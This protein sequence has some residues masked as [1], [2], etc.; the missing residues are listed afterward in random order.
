MGFIKGMVLSFMILIAICSATQGEIT[1]TTD[2]G[3]KVILD[4][5]GTW[6]YRESITVTKKSDTA[7][8]KLDLV[9]GKATVYYQSEKW[10]GLKETQP[11]R[12]ELS[13]RSGDVHCVIIAERLQMTLEAL[14]TLALN[15]GKE[16]A[17]DI[18]VVKED[19][20]VVNG[21]EILFMQLEGTITGVPFTYLGY[22]YAGPAGT[23]QTLTMTG[24]NLLDEYR[25][26]M[27]EFLN[28]FTVIK[29]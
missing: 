5:N 20:R 17:P 8:A 3:K 29:E 21:K 15:N 10:K 22:Y 19:R 24:Q 12:Y 18:K 27:M 2:N 23:I 26:D 13:H 1:A 16:A 25:T 28:G 11:G 14:R 9:R 7:N 4:E 6:K